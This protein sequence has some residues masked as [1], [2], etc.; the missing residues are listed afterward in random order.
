MSYVRRNKRCV[1]L[2]NKT[3][4]QTVL[5]Q[6]LVPAVKGFLQSDII[7]RVQW[8]VEDTITSLS[9]MISLTL[10]SLSAVRSIARLDMQER[11]AVGAEESDNRVLA[12]S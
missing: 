1:T 12:A 7:I 10:W 5:K 11:T 6:L 9:S 3:N 8:R 2:K 4:H